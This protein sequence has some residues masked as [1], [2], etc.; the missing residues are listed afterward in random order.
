MFPADSVFDRTNSWPMPAR[1][2]VGRSGRGRAVP[3]R[4]PWL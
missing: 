4:S 1:Q 3:G 2:R